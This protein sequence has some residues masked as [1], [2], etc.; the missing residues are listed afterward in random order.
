VVLCAQRRGAALSDTVERDVE[1]AVRK[2]AAQVHRASSAVLLCQFAEGECSECLRDLLAL[3][4]AHA[5]CASTGTQSRGMR[6]TDGRSGI[7]RGVA[8][9][10][11][12]AREL[13][14][15]GLMLHGH[16]QEVAAQG[17]RA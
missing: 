14:E 16:L 9:P 5:H 4:E 12:G 1:L 3:D 8:V 6:P 17:L 13:S 10:E 15:W 11:P 2:Q 7:G